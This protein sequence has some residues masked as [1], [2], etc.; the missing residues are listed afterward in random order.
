MG[1]IGYRQLL[2]PHLLLATVVSARPILSL[3]AANQ[4]P[5]HKNIPCIGGVI[6]SIEK[7]QIAH[8][9]SKR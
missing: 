6:Q 8:R 5:A 2:L 4:T 9:H 1:C 3:I 7:E